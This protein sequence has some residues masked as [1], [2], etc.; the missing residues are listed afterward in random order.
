MSTECGISRVRLPIILAVW[1]TGI[2]DVRPVPA[3]GMLYFTWLFFAGSHC[4]S[5]KL[6][7]AF[8]NTSQECLSDASGVSTK[9][10]RRSLQACP[11]ISVHSRRHVTGEPY[12]ARSMPPARDDPP[13]PPPDVQRQSPH[14]VLAPSCFGTTLEAGLPLLCVPCSLPPPA[15]SSSAGAS[16]RTR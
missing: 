8:G 7:T 11:D 2:S 4:L 9:A 1:S 6:T 16:T 3:A 12:K 10:Y 5:I 14:V 13:P 15:C